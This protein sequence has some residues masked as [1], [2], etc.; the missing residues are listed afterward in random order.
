MTAWLGIL[1]SLVVLTGVSEHWALWFILWLS[2]L[3]FVNVGQTFYSF[4]WE[5]M[6]LEA[7]F[8]ACF[9]ETVNP[10]NSA[11]VMLLFRWFLFRVMFGAG[12]IKLRGDKCWRDLTCLYYH[13][14][15]QPIPNR[16]SWYFHWL[17]KPVH[18]VGVVVNH[19]IELGIPFLYFAPQPIAFWAGMITIGF[20][21]WLTIS[22][23]FAFL[24]FLTMILAFSTFGFVAPAFAV[25][26]FS[27]ESCWIWGLA[28]V[29]ILLSYFPVKNMVSRDQSMNFSFN[30]FHIVG[31]YGA[32]GSI[33]RPRFEIIIEGSDNG[34]DWK[35]YE[36]IGKPGNLK[37]S[38]IQIAPYHLRLDWL[39]WFAAFSS[40]YQHPWFV[41]LLG[42]LMENRPEIL[43]LMRTNPFQNKPPA[44]I[45]A[46]LYKYQFTTPTQRKMTG[47][48]WQRE[49]VGVYAR[50]NM[51]NRVELLG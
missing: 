6:L 41:R 40:P 9:L 38:G 42:Q 45:R 19:I 47:N 44:E 46:L 35:E 36:F 4:G 26:V 51:T 30:P 25:P 1:I 39:M 48:F 18:R 20:H 14:E 34:L 7:G 2:Y 33:T 24:G 12:L 49:L 21:A 17:P 10:Q 11:I 23:N 50:A 27:L 5:S 8:L 3:S 31:T 13:Y 29:T 37:R 43:R 22:G 28:G 32:F 16:L 15:T